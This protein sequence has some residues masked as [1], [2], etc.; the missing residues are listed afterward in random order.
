MA[1]INARRLNASLSTWR[2]ILI[3]F[4]GLIVDIFLGIRYDTSTWVDLGFYLA[5]LFAIWQFDLVPQEAVYRER[6][7]A[8]GKAGGWLWPLIYGTPLGLFVLFVFVVYPLQPPTAREVCDQLM[9]APDLASVKKLTSPRLWPALD[10]H[11]NEIGWGQQAR[12]SIEEFEAPPDLGGTIVSFKVYDNSRQVIYVAVQLIQRDN[13]WTVHEIYHRK[14]A[15]PPTEE[16]TAFSVDPSFNPM[17]GYKIYP[18]TAPGKD[19]ADW[20][21][22]RRMHYKPTPTR[23]GL[24]GMF[25]ALYSINPLL[26]WGAV[27]LLI[28]VKSWMYSDSTSSKKQ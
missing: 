12:R 14:F 9:L 26:A 19:F 18:K 27:I 24:L 11:G 10:A 22:S 8:G 6:Q 5:T 28:V 4:G 13:R 20:A 1:G 17:T 25:D 2:P 23:H 15:E 3:G 7:T 21:A 16:L